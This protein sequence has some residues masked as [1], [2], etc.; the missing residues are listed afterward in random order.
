MSGENSMGANRQI[1]LNR[2]NLMTGAQASYEEL[3]KRLERKDLP[4]WEDLTAGAMD[5]WVQIFKAGLK[6]SRPIQ[7]ML[8]TKSA[9]G[10]SFTKRETR[11]QCRMH[12]TKSGNELGGT[13][14]L[15]RN[16]VTDGAN[17]KPK[18]AY[19]KNQ[20]G[21]VTVTKVN[22]LAWVYALAL[23]KNDV[24]RLKVVDAN[25]VMVVN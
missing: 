18:R 9:S 23:A 6:A 20:S 16:A 10:E 11:Y 13:M 17:K 14:Q 8:W 21:P 3:R 1:P 12:S 25:T 4:P 5:Q 15:H 22:P 19:R 24:K 2:F 7:S